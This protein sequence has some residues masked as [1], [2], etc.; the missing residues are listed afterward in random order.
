[1]AKSLVSMVTAILL[2]APAAAAQT[3]EPQTPS[4]AL[5]AILV[6][7]EGGALSES[8][9]SALYAL[10]LG[11]TTTFPT[12]TA[13]GG[14]SWVFD[15]N[16]QVPVRRNRSFGPMFA[17]RPFTTGKGRINVGAAFQ[18]TTFSSIGGRSLTELEILNTSSNGDEIYQRIASLEV[19]LD[20]TIVSATY[21]VHDRIDLAAIVPFGTAR[22]SGFNSYFEQ[23]VGGTSNQRID[24]SGSSFGLGDILVRTKVAL[25]ASARFDAA[26]AV[27]VRLPTGDPEKLLGTGQTQ[28]RVL[29]VGGT[30]LGKVN[31]H[32]NIGYTF[33]G[34]GMKFGP[35]DRWEGS[36]G[37]AQLVVTPQPSPEF[38]YV[39]GADVA[40]TS[41]ITVAGDLIGRMVRHS[42]D[43]TFVETLGAERSIK[44][45]VTPA[46]VH[47]LLGAV[48]A[49]VSIGGAWLLTGTVLFP[50]NNNGI[51]PAVTPVIGF[52]RAF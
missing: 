16:L 41:R 26:A 48:G 7:E 43:M 44:L 1:M 8:S 29:F 15:D 22:V 38:N 27:D 47:L 5:R 32:V 9:T 10:L 49:K 39:A 37:E 52:E 46:T 3:E 36:S 31:P 20:R 30:T 6:Q 25:I 23:S 33:G 17:E 4:S 2:A 45:E 18:H 42:A 21:G 50:L 13:A 34:D 19:Q 12:G 14:F 40:A 11:Q 28:G 24:S 35:D 51:K